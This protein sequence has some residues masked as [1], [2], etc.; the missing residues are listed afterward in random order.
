[1]NLYSPKPWPAVGAASLSSVLVT[2]LLINRLY[3]KKNSFVVKRKGETQPCIITC[4][5]HGEQQQSGGVERL[6][7]HDEGPRVG[8]GAHRL[9]CPAEGKHQAQSGGAQ[10]HHRGENCKNPLSFQGWEKN[11]VLVSDQITVAP[12]MFS[13]IC[14]PLEQSSALRTEW[15]HK[16]EWKKQR[17]HNKSARVCTTGSVMSE[18]AVKTKDTSDFNRRSVVFFWFWFF[19]PAQ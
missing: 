19:S 15:P 8:V 2:L 6:S 5:Q 12:W 11:D 1:M 10:S 4:G 7:C 17:S 16:L 3:L 18:L 13:L 14:S 9:G